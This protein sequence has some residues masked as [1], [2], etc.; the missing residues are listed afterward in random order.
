MKRLIAAMLLAC[1]LAGCQRAAPSAQAPEPAATA[2]AT[3]DFGTL[4]L[5]LAR[6]EITTVDRLD[7]RLVL[8]HGVGVSAGELHFAPEEA[9][10][11]V[12]SSES[13]Q[14]T[15]L[16]DG[17]VRME[18]HFLLEPF[19]DGAYQ[20]PPAG[21]ELSDG[22]E[23]AAVSTPPQPVTV[24]SILAGDGVEMA[25]VR[26]PVESVA[27]ASGSARPI[28]IGG[29]VA[30]LLL[31]GGA[32]WWWRHVQRSNTSGPEPNVQQAGARAQAADV[33]RLLRNRLASRVGTL[34]ATATSDEVIEAARVRLGA[35]EA[36]RVQ[37]LLA[38]IDRLCYGP[39][40]PGEVDVAAVSAAVASLELHAQEAHA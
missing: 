12:A 5:S 17:R 2:Q 18:W 21:I 22:R 16:P 28:L 4:K 10:W 38:C 7:V 23:S 11:T 1:S 26:P 39:E 14:P 25:P 30:G 35:P 15:I 6:T 19:L 29:L 24:T 40:E 9:G 32:L 20:V 3:S 31:A 8:E 34:P 33:R 13:L 36:A 27:H 37:Q